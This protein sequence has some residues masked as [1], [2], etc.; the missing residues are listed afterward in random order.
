MLKRILF[1]DDEPNVLQAFER[2]FRKQFEIHTAVGPAPGLT[3]VAEN[4]PFSVIVSDLRMPGM[5]GIEFLTRV[6]QMAPDTVR[7]MLTGQADL[8]ASIAAVNHGNIFQFLT[9]PC[10]SETLARVLDS[11]FEQYRLVT[12]ERELLEQT[13]RGSIG[14]MSE[15]LGLVNPIAFSRTVRIR[16]YVGHMAQ[17][18][19]LADQWQF[20]LAA[21]L[22]QIGC[23]AVPE[24]LLEKFDGGKLL[25]AAEREILSTQ[26]RVGHDLLTHIPRLEGIAEMVANQE[27]TCQELAGV[28]KAIAV[29]AQLLKVALDFDGM[30]RTGG[31]VDDVLSSMRSRKEYNQAFVAALDDLHAQD[32]MRT[33]RLVSLTQLK[34]QMITN[35]DVRSRNGLLLLAKGQEIQDSTILRLK[36]FALTVGVVEPISVLV[37]HR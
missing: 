15:I 29:G 9:K 8:G 3:A 6:R 7:V 19:N 26:K 10:P 2:Q 34:T 13:L 25:D 35:C 31:S 17:K 22:C 24:E 12:A 30:M 4:G 16:R 33:A 18:L 28:P 21:M 14:V 1:V 20:D 32:A 37:A 36:S 23:V 11:A 27:A 5:D